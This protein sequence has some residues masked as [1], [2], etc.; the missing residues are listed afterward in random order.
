M[1]C[2]WVG[3]FLQESRM[4]ILSQG[5]DFLGRSLLFSPRPRLYHNLGSFS[6]CLLDDLSRKNSLA[7]CQNSGWLFS[8]VR[9]AVHQPWGN[10]R[11][12]KKN[13]VFEREQVKPNLDQEWH[14]MSWGVSGILAFVTFT[15]RHV[16]HC[17]I[18]SFISLF[19]LGQYIH[20]A[21]RRR[22]P[23]IPRFELWRFYSIFMLHAE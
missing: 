19:M 2:L 5:Y 15:V 6:S 12:N 21:A 8:Q 22:V 10:Q 20:S 14:C 9:L 17:E 11:S 7:K 4:R 23:V 3:V 13:D 18:K 16:S 1:P